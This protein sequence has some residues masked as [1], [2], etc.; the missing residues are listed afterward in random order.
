[1]RRDAFFKRQKLAEPIQLA[2]T[3]LRDVDPRVAIADRA[4]ESYEDHFDERIVLSPIDPGIGNF[5]KVF[6]DSTNECQG[7][8]FDLRADRLQVEG[9]R[10]EAFPADSLL[11]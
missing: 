5:F 6:V 8:W 4:A 7:H 3:E 1:V 9:P 10:T 2:P 11:Q